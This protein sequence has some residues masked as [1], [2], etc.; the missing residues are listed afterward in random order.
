MTIIGQTKN[1]SGFAVEL[2]EAAAQLVTSSPNKEWSGKTTE[3]EM[4]K[5]AEQFLGMLEFVFAAPEPLRRELVVIVKSNLAQLCVDVLE[6][7]EY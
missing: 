2:S 5:C 3:E 1:G 7:L 6:A 4:T